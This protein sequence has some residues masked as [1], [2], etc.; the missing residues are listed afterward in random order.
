MAW[1]KQHFEFIAATLAD[2]QPQVGEAGRDIWLKITQEF[3]R[4]LGR[5]NQAFDHVRF[6]LAATRILANLDD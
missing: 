5:T 3:T 4:R 2:T 6:Q 1:S